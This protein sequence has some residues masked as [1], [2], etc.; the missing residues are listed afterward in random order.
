[1]Y[2]SKN[3]VAFSSTIILHLIVVLVVCCI[4]IAFM[5]CEFICVF[6]SPVLRVHMG[7]TVKILV[8]E[9]RYGISRVTNFFSMLLKWTRTLPR[10]SLSLFH[11]FS[12]NTPPCNSFFFPPSFFCWLF[13][14]HFIIDSEEHWFDSKILVSFLWWSILLLLLLLSAASWLHWCCFDQFV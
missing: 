1:M 11:H 12:I 6:V 7:T 4:C 14:N 8:F 10:T 2:Q 5:L 13:F 3:T 9:Y